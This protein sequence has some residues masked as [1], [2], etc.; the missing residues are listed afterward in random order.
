MNL[1]ILINNLNKIIF[2]K[3]ISVIHK[4]I[5][6]FSAVIIFFV[7]WEFL[8]IIGVFNPNFISSPSTIIIKIIEL[9][10]NGIIP[11]ETAYTLIRV[12]IGVSLALIVAI[13]LGFLLG[14]FFKKIE[15]SLNPLLRLLEQI[16][17][18]TLFHLIILFT[19]INELAIV[20]VI[21][22]AVQWPLLNNTVTGAKNVPSEF[23]KIG[24]SLN[25]SKS[26]IFWKIQL[27]S[28]LPYIFTGLRLG[29]IFAFLIAMGVEM[30]GMTTG[31]GLGYF[32]MHSQETGYVP[33]MWAGVAVMTI[34]AVLVNYSITLIEK[35]FYRIENL[36]F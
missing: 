20:L 23:I 4:I 10:L 35:E 7:I 21:Y 11:F 6:K 26:D 34:L 25:F 19:L 3:F 17:P 9:S 28:A 31:N 2:N 15:N 36:L 8:S 12:L 27:P 30:M 1:I 22:W 14:G 33:D 18:L 5:H 29:V 13:P 24:K 16:N 32:I